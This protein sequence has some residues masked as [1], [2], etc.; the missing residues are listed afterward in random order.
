MRVME[1]VLEHPAPGTR[2]GTSSLQ[3]PDVRSLANVLEMDQEAVYDVLHTLHK[4]VPQLLLQTTTGSK[5]GSLGYTL[6]L[7]ELM[8]TMK[9]RTVTVSVRAR[10]GSSAARIFRLL[11]DRKHLE[12][13]QV[14]EFAM[15]PLKDAKALCYTMYQDGLLSLQEIPQTADHKPSTC[16]FTW[17]IE[18]RR[19][20]EREYT[21]VYKAMANYRRYLS[22]MA[23]QLLPD[24]KRR[25]LQ[26]AVLQM[27]HTLLVLQ[28]D[29]PAPSLF[30]RPIDEDA[31]KAQVTR[32]RK[33]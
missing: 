15:L 19:V 7:D 4:A 16:F 3:T 23:G 1:Y 14:A 25:R 18:Q 28:H 12:E 26:A 33:A 17:F 6:A 32:K 8:H 2:G 30:F 11:L 13:K 10:H 27:D 24:D 21:R 31:K 9:H 5:I 20:L 29:E 22:S